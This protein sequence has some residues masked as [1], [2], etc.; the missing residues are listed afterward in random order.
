M[1]PNYEKVKRYYDTDLWSIEQVYKSVGKWITPE[2][3]AQITG[4]VYI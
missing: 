3:F 2:E 4:E 1:S